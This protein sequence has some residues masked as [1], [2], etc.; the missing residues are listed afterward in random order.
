MYLFELTP[1]I[2]AAL[3]RLEALRAA[4]DT[5]GVLPRRWLGRL[6]RDLEAEAVAAS[7]TME[8]VPVTV[9]EVRRILVGD[10]PR[11]VS[12]ADAGDRT[13]NPMPPS[14]HPRNQGQDLLLGQVG[15]HLRLD[16]AWRHGVHGR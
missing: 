6:R 12:E 16:D 8:G 5:R 11:T 15:G 10:R 14:V 9:D 1:E 2:E 3:G 13:F 4:L 7:T